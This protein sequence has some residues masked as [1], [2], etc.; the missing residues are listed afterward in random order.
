MGIP[1]ICHHHTVRFG[2]PQRKAA[3]LCALAMIRFF[4]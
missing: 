3:D 1:A 4:L 2:V